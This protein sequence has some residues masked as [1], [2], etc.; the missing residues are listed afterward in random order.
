MDEVMQVAFEIK[1]KI[2]D[3]EYMKLVEKIT[4]V[5]TSRH[6]SVNYGSRTVSDT[7]MGHGQ[8]LQQKYRQLTEKFN[9]ET[10]KYMKIIADLAEDNIQLRRDLAEWDDD[11]DE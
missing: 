11:D 7:P 10:T 8:N 6:V 3:A 9:K 1:E 5:N 2:T 4:D